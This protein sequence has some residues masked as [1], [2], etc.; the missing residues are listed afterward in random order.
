MKIRGG[1]TPTPFVKLDTSRTQKVQ[2]FTLIEMLVVTVMLSVISLAIYA[3]FNNG[4][5][6]WQK[7]NKPIPQE[8]LYIFLDR[9]VSDVKNTFK[10]TGLNFLGKVDRLEFPALVDS[11]RLNKKTVG[12]VVYFY[13][14]T[15]G[16]LNR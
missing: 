16:A 3:T 4:I 11:P 12:Q 9:F 13:N 6:I 8:D 5:K 15:S 7:I 2:G 10:F 14:S 1:F